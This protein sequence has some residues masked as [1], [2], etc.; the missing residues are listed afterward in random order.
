MSERI[1]LAAE[2]QFPGFSGQFRIGGTVCFRDQFL[3]FGSR[4]LGGCLGMSFVRFADNGG[5]RPETV[6]ISLDFMDDMENLPTVFINQYDL[7][8]ILA[9][10]ISGHHDFLAD[11][12]ARYGRYIIVFAAE[13]NL[14]C[15]RD[16]SAFRLGDRQFTAYL[17][18]GR[19]DQ[20]VRSDR[21]P[22]GVARPACPAVDAGRVEVDTPSSGDVVQCIQ[23]VDALQF[24]AGFQLRFNQ[25]VGVFHLSLGPC[26]ARFVDLQDNA[27]RMA[28]VFRHAGGI[29]R[30]GIQHQH[31][32]D[33]VH[34]VLSSPFL[35][36][37]DQDMAKVFPGFRTQDIFHV[38]PAAG[39]VGNHVTPD[40][41][42]GDAFRIGRLVLV[43]HLRR[44]ALYAV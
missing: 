30:A 1:D 15:R 8:R 22:D 35:H 12:D 24:Q 31:F 25:F 16:F 26:I 18:G 41:V 11:H 2:R 9:P 40:T 34:D 23:A 6:F 27:Q 7:G 38:Q 28:Q 5:V 33:T 17:H 43:I 13:R 37:I 44:H 14:Q 10:W 21:H 4:F 39:M 29:G 36:G 42:G 20:L 32:R 3:D 19:L